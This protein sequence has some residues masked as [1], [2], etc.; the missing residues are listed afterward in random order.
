[1]SPNFKDPA[2]RR[3]K[4]SLR[5]SPESAAFLD[6]LEAKTVER[7]LSRRPNRSL[8]ADLCVAY[9]RF[10]ASKGIDILAMRGVK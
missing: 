4:E 10:A 9:A 3:R 7:H 2:R 5:L 6:E 1:M 8:A